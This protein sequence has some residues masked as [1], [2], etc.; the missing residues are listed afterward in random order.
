MPTKLWVAV[1]AL[2]AELRVN[3]HAECNGFFPRQ[4]RD[5]IPNHF[6]EFTER[7]SLN[8]RPHFVLKVAWFF[9]CMVRLRYEL[10]LIGFCFL[11]LSLTAQ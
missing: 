2:V 6:D 4:S 9:I 3:A 11:G 5:I 10:V 7:S 1:Y 8:W